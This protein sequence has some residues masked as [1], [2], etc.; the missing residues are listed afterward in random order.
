MEWPLAVLAA[1]GLGVIAWFAWGFARDSSS[2]ATHRP[3]A[4]TGYSLW[5]WRGGRWQLTEDRSKPGHVPGPEPSGVGRAEGFVTRVG[6]V[7]K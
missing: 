2:D 1:A 5:A 7:R 4:E 3:F 6:S